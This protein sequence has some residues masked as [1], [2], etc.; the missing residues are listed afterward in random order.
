[1]SPATAEGKICPHLNWQ[2]SGHFIALV[3][4]GKEGDCYTALN[5]TASTSRPSCW[6][7]ARKFFYGE[8]RDWG[9]PP[10]VVKKE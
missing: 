1:M 10:S 5:T 4:R 3:G 2:F 8:A 7:S 9:E 6:W